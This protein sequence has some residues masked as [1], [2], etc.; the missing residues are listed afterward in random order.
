[1]KTLKFTVEGGQ[2]RPGPPLGPTLSQMGINV[3]EAVKRIN[4]VTADFKG[5]T[6]PVTLEIDTDTKKYEVKVGIPTTTALLLKA[7]GAQTPSGDPA[8]KKIGNISLKDV[9]NV[10][11]TKKDSLTAKT[12]EGAVITILSSAATIGLTVENE[13][14]KKVISDIYNNKY[15]EML[16]EFQ[17]KWGN[18]S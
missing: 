17:S 1:M 5:M 18:S 3:A 2:A 16:K 15:S 13:E 9:V 14:P 6:V 7:A 4:D 11:I 12:L 10:A 8:H